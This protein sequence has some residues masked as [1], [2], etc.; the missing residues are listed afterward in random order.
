MRILHI[1]KFFDFH[2]G[3]EVYLQEL[4]ERQRAAGHEVAVLATKKPGSTPTPYDVVFPEYHAYDRREGPIKDAKKALDYVWNR[5][6]KR[7]TKTMIDRFRPNVIHVHNLYH[8][9][10]TSVLAPIRA[11]GIRCVQTLHDYKLVCPNYKLYTENT[12][13]ERC[14]GGRYREAIVHGCLGSFLPNALAVIEMNVTK[15]RQSYEKTVH[16][17]LCP[18]RFMQSTMIEWGEPEEKMRYLPNPTHVPARVAMR[19]GGYLLFAGRLYPEKGLASVLEALAEFPDVS[20]WIT[21]RGPEEAKLKMIVDAKG[22]ASVRFLGFVP[23]E[24]LS[25]IRDR[26][27]A[28]VL[29]TLMHENAS[30][31]LLEAMA[32]GLPCLTT[33]VGG[34]PELVEDGVNGLLAEAG[35]VSDWKRVLHAFRAATPEQRTA[36]GVAGRAKVID[37]FTWERHLA[38]LEQ[39]YL[40]A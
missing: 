18:S 15:A 31:A 2:G 40:G 7:A 21:G 37:R 9:L 36:W 32:A 5:E 22:L 24:Q 34:N 3:A 8:H 17:F 6:A 10:S 29:P 23:P 12:I 14:K 16:R 1:N 25:E 26:A 38:A 11:S 4:V 33:R 13:C 20:L 39:A 19:G 28:L 30:G 27:E 35:S